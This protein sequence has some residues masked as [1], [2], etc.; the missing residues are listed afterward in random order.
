MMKHMLAK[1][2]LA[3]LLTTVLS[4][5]ANLL[6][7]KQ[8]QSICEAKCTATHILDVD[9]KAKES[10]KTKCL[11]ARTVCEIEQG[12]AAAVEMMHNAAEQ[13]KAFWEGMKEASADKDATKP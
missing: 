4:A 3:S 9:N 5:Q 7:C 10:C 11:G 1:V 13:G 12:K 2:V 8:E 6:D